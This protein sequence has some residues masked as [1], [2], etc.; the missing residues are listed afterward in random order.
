MKL[1]PSFSFLFG[2]KEKTKEAKIKEKPDKNIYLEV[3]G[4]EDAK[5]VNPQKTPDILRKTLI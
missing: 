4:L 2:R 5:M 1:S 3:A